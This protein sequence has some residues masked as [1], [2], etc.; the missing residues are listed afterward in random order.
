MD[1]FSLLSSLMCASLCKQKRKKIT[2]KKSCFFFGVWAKRNIPPFFCLLFEKKVKARVLPPFSSLTE[3]KL[4][5][6]FS[7]FCFFVFIFLYGFSF[8]LSLSLSFVRWPSVN[9][10][11][12][13]SCRV[14]NGLSE[15]NGCTSVFL[16]VYVFIF[17][18]V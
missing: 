13:I 18:F 8:F 3:K 6:V 10:V 4:I 15:S 9:C 2:K 11:F 5:D 12:H 1:V 14:L 17:C 7:R 16:S